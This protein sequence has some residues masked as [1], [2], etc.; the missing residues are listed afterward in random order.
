M[1]P[2]PK[3]AYR[4]R[5]R[6]ESA[7]GCAQAPAQNDGP[8]T[9]HQHA[10]DPPFAFA[11]SDPEDKPASASA[12]EGWRL[13]FLAISAHRVHQR[14]VAV[15]EAAASRSTARSMQTGNRLRP[16]QHHPCRRGC[17]RIRTSSRPI[18]ERSDRPRPSAACSAEGLSSLQAPGDD[19]TKAC[20]R[21]AYRADPC[22]VSCSAMVHRTAVE[23]STARRTDAHRRVAAHPQGDGILE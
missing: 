7:Q 22:R 21:P 23:I 18:P 15:D 3:A 5:Q 4:R 19:P 9:D 11:H 13:A 17:A 8:S 16:D 20:R 1:N 6:A 2:N 10:T 14:H 12:P